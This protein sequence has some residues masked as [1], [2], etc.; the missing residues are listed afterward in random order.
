MKSPPLSAAS[1]CV[2]FDT[3]MRQKEQ[4][5]HVKRVMASDKIKQQAAKTSESHAVPPY[6]TKP[7]EVK[8]PNTSN[9]KARQTLYDRIQ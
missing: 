5:D 6:K 9:P 3:N 7:V 2:F 4:I 1:G 8:K